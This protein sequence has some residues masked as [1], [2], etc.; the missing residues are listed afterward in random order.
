MNR[1]PAISNDVPIGKRIKGAEMLSIM[2]GTARREPH[3]RPFLHPRRGGSAE[4]EIRNYLLTSSI[5]IQA[6]LATRKPGVVI[7]PSSGGR[8][9]TFGSGKRG[10]K[11]LATPEITPQMIRAGVDCLWRLSEVRASDELVQGG[12][13]AMLAE[14]PSSPAG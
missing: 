6:R 11:A 14:S 13:L 10:G 12:Y 8:A 7:R 1:M 2:L 4:G 3:E 9:Y 5:P